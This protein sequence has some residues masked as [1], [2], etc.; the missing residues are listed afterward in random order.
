MSGKKYFLPC[1]IIRDYTGKFS[2]NQTSPKK[3]LA[4]AQRL[5]LF[6]VS[7]RIVTSGSVSKNTMAAP[8]FMHTSYKFTFP[9][10]KKSVP[11][12]PVFPHNSHRSSHS[13]PQHYFQTVHALSRWPVHPPV[14]KDPGHTIETFMPRLRAAPPRMKARIAPCYALP[15]S[16]PKVFAKSAVY[17]S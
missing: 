11:S 4:T 7:P 1:A 3:S 12:F 10:H 2:N 8:A 13:H 6:T 14:R 16:W 15:Q 17:W 5:L 9:Q